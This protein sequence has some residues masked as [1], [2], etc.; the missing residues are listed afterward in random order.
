MPHAS[1][2]ISGQHH[3]LS[4]ASL[5][6]ALIASVASAQPVIETFDT[7]AA[8]FSVYSD[9]LAFQWSP[10]LG[11]PG[12][13]V[14]ATDDVAGVIWGFTAGPA[15][16]GD[17]SCF[18]GG[19]LTYDLFVNIGGNVGPT[20]PD[21]ALIGAGITLAYD[22]PLAM[23]SATWTTRSVTLS[24]AGWRVGTLTGPTPTQSQ[25]D[26]VLANLQEVRL[27]AEH[28]SGSDNGRI[29]N[30]RLIPALG[31]SCTCDSLDFNA[32]SLF[33]DDADLIDLLSV[34]AGGPCSTGTCNDIDFN[35]D[36][37]FPDDNDLIAFL[38]VLA[39]GTCP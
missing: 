1:F 17:K 10:T 22:I 20:E 39:G 2:V 35:N 38:T 6:L 3:V 14:T 7:G 5:S 26:A 29:D 4:A 28:R 13:C 25:F 8:G 33:P 21:F 23:A 24:P 32:D 16:L 36:G 34:L 11:N 12:G 30:V 37:L 9:A 18:A 27:R 19:T 15:F 31:V